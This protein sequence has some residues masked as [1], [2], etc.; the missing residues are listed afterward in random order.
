MLIA[1]LLQY[2]IIV[3]TGDTVGGRPL[4]ILMLGALALIAARLK[5]NRAAVWWAVGLTAALLAVVAPVSATASARVASGVVGAA[6]LVL[7]IVTIGIIGSTLKA[8]WRVDTATVLGV[9]CIYLLFALV[10]AS[11]HQ[12]LAS[13]STDYL[14]GVSGQP[15]A[16]A[17]LYF[18][19][20][21][22]A[23]VGYGDL[24]PAT[25]AGRAVAVT[26]ALVGQLYLVSVVAVV[27]SGWRRDG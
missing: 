27:V 25:E 3:T 6:T 22:M 18:S 14:N 13:F 24:T 7:A 17:L 8:R 21:T 20:I 4:R 19:V 23:T 11:L 9:L 12:L 5:A 1:I 15:S 16:S 2:M 26:E 10:F